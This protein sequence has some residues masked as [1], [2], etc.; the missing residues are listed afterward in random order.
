MPRAGVDGLGAG[1]GGHD[2]GVDGAADVVDEAADLLG[3]AGDAVGQLADLV[4]DDGEAPAGVARAGGFDRGVDGQD[5]GLL[6]Q[7]EDDVEH[8]ADL[9][10]LLAELEHVA[11]DQ[12]DLRRMLAIDS[13]GLVAPCARP[14]APR[15]AVWSAICATR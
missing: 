12:V 8:A 13:L 6:G 10:R 9:L 4:G 5:V 14:R 11:D 15:V 7:L 1:L 2:G 3:R